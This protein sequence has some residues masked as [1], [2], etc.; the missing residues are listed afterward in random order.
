VQLKGSGWWVKQHRAKARSMQQTSCPPR[1]VIMDK[2]MP[3]MGGI[4]ATRL[5]T[6]CH[7]EVVL[8]LVSEEDPDTQLVGHVVPPRSLASRRFPQ[9]RSGRWC[10]SSASERLASSKRRDGRSGNPDRAEQAPPLDGKDDS[11]TGSACKLLASTLVKTC[12]S[13][14]RCGTRPDLVACLRCRDSRSAA[15][16]RRSLV[17]RH[18]CARDIVLTV[19]DVTAGGSRAAERQQLACE[20]ALS[21]AARLGIHAQQAVILEDW[22]NTLIRLAPTP[23]VAKVGTS[24]I[25]DARLESLERELSVG[26]HLAACGAPVIPPSRQVPAGPHHWQGLTLTLWQH[27]EPVSDA[28]PAPAQMAAA[29]QMVHEALSDFGG[30][31]PYFALELDDARRLLHPHRSPLLGAADRRFLLSVASELEGALARPPAQCRQLHGSPQSANWLLSA[32]GPLLLDFETACYGPVE[33]DLAAV[34]KKVLD[35]FP[36]ADRAMIA[37]MRRMRSVCV[38][39]KCWVAPERAPQLREAADVHLKLLRGQPLD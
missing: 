24:H 2:R 16:C 14:A 33:W 15:L 10:A 3:G 4:E 8:L 28:E 17:G 34:G 29:L 36:D 31:L 37:T 20:A 39:A 21:V 25:R 1:M 12:A 19:W 7:P 11:A 13:S 22:N 35:F 32:H 27:V 23:I 38:A 5:L 18:G 30:P 9:L 6:A 26:A